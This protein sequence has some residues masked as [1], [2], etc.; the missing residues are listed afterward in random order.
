M[1][2]KSEQNVSDEDESVADDSNVSDDESNE[3]D[4]GA[5]A[6]ESDE[7]E[8]DDDD[9]DDG[10]GDSLDGSE[11]SSD[12][13]DTTPT[14]SK[15][16]IIEEQIHS[17]YGQLK[18]TRLFV[19]FPQKLPLDEQEFNKKVKALHP[20]VSK[21]SKPRQKHARFCLVEFKSQEERDKA[22]QDIKASIESDAAF[23]GLYVS[24]PK[25]DS[26]EFVQELVARKQQSIQKRKTKALTKRATKQVARKSKFTSSVVITNLPKTASVA[27]VRQIFE[28]AVDIQLKPGKGKFREYNAAT[29]T[30]PS[31][32]EARSALKRDFN[33][34]GSKLHLRYNTQQNYQKLRRLKKNLKR[35]AGK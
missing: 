26:D 19:R 17:K 24:L 7:D 9:D 20:L 27:Q 14:K 3:M 4:L 22:L 21:A 13:E 34:A 28:N 18:G 2:K 1:L 8:D 30:L 25:T 5:S 15:A 16:K 29:I 35:K 11:F 12:K 33:I 23:K 6:T 32:F 10:S 31:T